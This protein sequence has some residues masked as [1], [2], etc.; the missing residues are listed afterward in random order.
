MPA[1]C[2]SPAAALLSAL[3]LATPIVVGPATPPPVAAQD[4][5]QDAEPGATR[6]ERGV[7]GSVLRSGPMVGHGTHRTT[8]LWLQT[9]EAAQVRIRYWNAARPDSSLSTEVVRTK[10]ARDFAHT[11]HLTDLE[12]GQTYEYEIV[13]EG[14]VVERPYPLRFQTQELWQYRREPPAFTVALGSCA[15][16]NDPRFDRPGDPYGGG[17]QIFQSIAALEPELMLWTGDNVYY[18]T[19]D[20]DAPRM[21]G[22]RYAH[23]RATPEMQELLA[24]GHHYATW[25]DHDYGP[26]NADRSYHLKD[27][28]LEVFKRYWANPSYGLPSEPGVF[29]KFSWNGVDFFLLDD[30]YHRSPNSAPRAGDKTMWGSG[31][32]QWLIDALTTSNAPFKVVVNGGQI[33]NR[34]DRYETLARFPQD[35]QRLIDALTER[36]IE[37]VIFISGDRH[38]TE[39]LRRSEEGF[40]PLYDFTNSPLTAS[41][42]GPQGPEAENELRVDGTLVTQRNFGTLT[43]EGPREDRRLIMRTYDTGGKLLWERTVHAQDLTAE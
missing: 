38:R 20:F 10:D 28:A 16:I 30:R 17:Y 4:A 24:T 33:L 3:L 43:F 19:V 39:L 9:D 15:Y 1:R 40:Y 7:P 8:A 14:D 18:R 41:A 26:N 6:A 23:T 31:Q 5:A 21:L 13:A 29:T 11:F 32:L 42:G 2:F 22:D 36:E 34:Y 27:T 37:G 35:Y 25:D 12:P